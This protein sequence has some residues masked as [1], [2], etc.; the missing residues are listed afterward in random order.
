MDEQQNVEPVPEVA[1][2]GEEV[3][4][5]ADVEAV[6]GNITASMTP[7]GFA[8]FIRELGGPNTPIT[9][10]ELPETPE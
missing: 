8:A 1:L 10:E 3:L 9:V 7:A 4:V 5:F 6:K 2:T